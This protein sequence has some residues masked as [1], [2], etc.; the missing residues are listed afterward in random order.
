MGK[1]DDVRYVEEMNIEFNKPKPIEKEKEKEIIE[2]ISN[3]EK[4]EDLTALFNS[5]KRIATN[6]ILKP[7]FTAE[8]RN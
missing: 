5:D 8:I 6:Q 1:F 2:A 7:L 4:L 3:I